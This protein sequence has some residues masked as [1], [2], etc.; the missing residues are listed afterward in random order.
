LSFKLRSKSISSGA[1]VI[2]SYKYSLFFNGDPN[3]AVN[4]IPVAIAFSLPLII[5]IVLV[6]GRASLNG[7]LDVGRVMKGDFE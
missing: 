7:Q 2:V 1:L 4:L 6:S 3:Q 5:G